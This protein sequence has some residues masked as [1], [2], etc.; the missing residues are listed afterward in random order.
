MTPRTVM[1][2]L[3]QDMTVG[4]LLKR[5]RVLPYSR[6]PIYAETTDDIKLFVLRNE[7][8]MAAAQDRHDTPL[9]ELARPLH[10]IPE[11][12]TVDTVLNEFTTR[13]QHMFLVFD[14]YG[15]TAGIITMEDA[16]E[17]LIGVE[18]TD[19]SDLVADLRELAQQRYKRQQELLGIISEQK[20]EIT[21]L[22]EEAEDQAGEE[23]PSQEHSSPRE[24]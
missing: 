19:E 17:S 11:G 3:Q 15:G 21:E 16:V 6:M 5:H 24:S 20:T 4:E 7:V 22:K 14:E 18:I 1:F 13:Q 2:S 12:M 10:S 8:L 9:Q 23:P